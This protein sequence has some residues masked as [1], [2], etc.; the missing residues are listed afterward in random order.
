MLFKSG[1]NVTIGGEQFTM[2]DVRSVVAE[3]SGFGSHVHY[4]DSKKHFVSDG[5]NQV[6]RSTPCELCERVV[7]SLTE[8]RLCK[9]QRETDQKHFESLRNVRR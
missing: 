8:I 6:G 2:D 1:N 7:S 5:K 9:K 3:Y 4:Y